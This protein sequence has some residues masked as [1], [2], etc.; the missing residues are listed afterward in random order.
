MGRELT[1]RLPKL[2]A[3]ELVLEGL[4]EIQ[5][6]DRASGWELV[7]PVASSAAVVVTIFQTPATLKSV[8][9][10]CR[11]LLKRA[12]PEDGDRLEAVGPGGQLRLR[13]TQ[14]TDLAD[15]EQFLKRTIFTDLGQP[16]EPV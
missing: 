10:G 7:Y 14:Q 4:A 11:R 8:A 2:L 3:D 6:P 15:L 16:D 1:L 5:E 13:V 12:S 9:A